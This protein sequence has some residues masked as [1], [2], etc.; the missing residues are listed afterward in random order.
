MGDPLFQ[1][2]P[3]FNI[4]YEMFMPTG[5]KIRNTLFILII[6]LVCYFLITVALYDLD[7]S[8]KMVIEGSNIDILGILNGI[9]IFII[10]VLA[11]K[12]A[13]HLVV[14]IWQYNS[15]QYTFYEDFVEYQDTFLN[16]HK[17]TLRYDNIKEVE[18]RRTVW[19]RIN[20]YGMV[21]I[22]SNAEKASDKGLILY[23]I[24]NPEVVYE[25]IDEIIH[26]R[27]ATQKENSQLVK[28]VNPTDKVTEKEISFK[29]SL[30]NKE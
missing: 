2:K 23:S 10:V 26:N 28:N 12:L 19:D 17:K 14:Q 20:G 22:Y 8:K 5:R 27:F 29:E 24:K 3:N 18:I 30:N 7:I 4:I 25:K 6:S 1:I 13:I 11:L 21:I 15:I 16:Q 9:G